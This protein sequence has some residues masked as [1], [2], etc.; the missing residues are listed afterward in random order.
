[1]RT[2]FIGASKKTDD[3]NATIRL[4]DAKKSMER[5]NLFYLPLAGHFPSLSAA[6]SATF[7]ELPSFSLSAGNSCI[8]CVDLLFKTIFK[9]LATTATNK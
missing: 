3:G 7:D 5:G 9:L 8:G 2:F 1:M 6:V 4:T